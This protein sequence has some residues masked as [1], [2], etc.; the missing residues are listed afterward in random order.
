MHIDPTLDQV[1]AFQATAA[2]TAPVYM[3]NLL[4][5]KEQA[6]G[7]DEGTTGAEAYM[8]YSALAAGHL[9]RVGGELVWAG[10]CHDA[11]IGPQEREWDVVALVRY[12]SRAKFLEMVA[13]PEY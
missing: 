1:T 2:D 13:D 4:R 12:P 7:P 10:G 9:E 6:D 3:L 8:R 5:F 11:L